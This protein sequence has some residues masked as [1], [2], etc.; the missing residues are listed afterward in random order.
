MPF[1]AEVMAQGGVRFRLWAPGAKKVELEVYQH[2]P[3]LL[4]N[5]V[6]ASTRPCARPSNATHLALLKQPF[7]KVRF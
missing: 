5:L 2:I 6:V 7:P 1:G 4:T 3:H